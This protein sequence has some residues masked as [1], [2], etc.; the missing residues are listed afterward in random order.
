MKKTEFIYKPKIDSGKVF[1]PLEEVTIKKD[2]LFDKLL[3]KTYSQ[4]TGEE[5]Q[6]LE[7]EKNGSE[8]KLDNESDGTYIRVGVNTMSFDG[9]GLSKSYLWVL[10]NSKHLQKNYFKGITKETLPQLYEYIMSMDVFHCDYE[11]FKRGIYTDT[12]ICFDFPCRR[13]QFE[14]FKKNLKLS[15]KDD[16][17]WHSK[18]RKDNT[19]IYAPHKT[20]PREVAT[21]SNPYVKFYDKELDFEVKSSKFRDA[22]MKGV[23]YQEVFRYECTIKNRRHAKRL[24]LEETKTL[25]DLLDSDLH[26]LCSQM[27]REYFLKP[28]IVQV[29]KIRPMDRVIIDLMNIAIE[30][31]VDRYKLFAIFDREDVSR[32]SKSD[33]IKKYHSIMRTDEINK[34]QLESNEITKKIFDYLGVD[35][36]QLKIDFD[37]EDTSTK[38][39]S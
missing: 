24:G 5:Y 18:N 1:I 34:E 38:K 7:I 9:L 19:G 21:P 31:G 33:L 30:K 32:Q 16:T 4:T 6:E 27:F 2:Y 22:Y 17:K 13:N 15:V 37:K 26:V 29:G 14:I 3:V 12:D 10:I 39:P 20:K 23:E 25:W 8:F 35:M 36:E 11:T 28:K